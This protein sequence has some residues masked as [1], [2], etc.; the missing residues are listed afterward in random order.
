MLYKSLTSPAPPSAGGLF[1][2]AVASHRR[3][4][5]EGEQP[6]DGRAVLPAAGRLPA[7]GGPHLHGPS[8]AAGDPGVQSWRLA[9]QQHR[10]QVLLQ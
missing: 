4:A 10:P 1:G 5:G 2:A 9:A 8:A 3:A 7:T 6:S